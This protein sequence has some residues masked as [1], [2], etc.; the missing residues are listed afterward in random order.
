MT[1]YLLPILKMY[2][3][4][5]FCLT[6][7]LQFPHFFATDSFNICNEGIGAVQRFTHAKR[8]RGK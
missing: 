2:E 5:T 6:Q 8:Y 7:M 4:T 3:A 1:F